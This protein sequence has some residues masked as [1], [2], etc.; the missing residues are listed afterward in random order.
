MVNEEGTNVVLKAQQCR[1][2]VEFVAYLGTHFLVLS[3]GRG[4]ALL[5]SYPQVQE[6]T[7]RMGE[8]DIAGAI[9]QLSLAHRRSCGRDKAYLALNCSALELAQGD[10]DKSLDWYIDALGA[11]LNEEDDDAW[12]ATHAAVLGLCMCAA[13]F[14]PATW[15]PFTEWK[16]DMPSDKLVEFLGT[17]ANWTLK[18]VQEAEERRGD[19]EVFHHAAAAVYAAVTPHLFRAA[20]KAAGFRIDA[21]PMPMG[22]GGAEKRAQMVDELTQASWHFTPWIT[23]LRQQWSRLEQSVQRKER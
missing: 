13:S 15:R 4:G 6:A 1:S 5:H 22:E 18:G 9:Y 14:P 8:T 12:W 23:D 19:F 7:K 11:S 3:P 16:D 10:L 21:P 20:C 2:T 17:L